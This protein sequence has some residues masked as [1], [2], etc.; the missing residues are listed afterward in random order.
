MSRKSQI[1]PTICISLALAVSEIP[2]IRHCLHSS[3][4]AVRLYDGDFGHAAEA[5]IPEQYYRLSCLG[6]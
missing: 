3:G 5:T 6:A 4:A 1:R 2:L